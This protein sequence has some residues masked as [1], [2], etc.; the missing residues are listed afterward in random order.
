MLDN[1]CAIGATDTGSNLTVW[2]AD[3]FF[4]LDCK[5]LSEHNRACDDCGA[6]WA[7]DEKE[8]SYD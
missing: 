8:E 7:E 3:S 2:R 5:H 6:V 1:L 4:N